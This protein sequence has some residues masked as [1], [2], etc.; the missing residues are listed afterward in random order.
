MN[1][2][3]FKDEFRESKINSGT[4]CFNHYHLPLSS[5]NKIRNH[6]IRYD[7]VAI[8]F[9]RLMELFDLIVKLIYI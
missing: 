5:N 4:R 7:K 9:G 1:C 3:V 6:F 2:Y 8:R